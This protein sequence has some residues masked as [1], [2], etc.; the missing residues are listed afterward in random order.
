[1]IFDNKLDRQFAVETPYRFLAIDI[2]HARTLE[3]FVYLLLVIDRYSLLAVGRDTHGR[4]VPGAR[5][6]RRLCFQHARRPS[7]NGLW[8]EQTLTINE[9]AKG[10]WSAGTSFLV[11]LSFKTGLEPAIRS[12]RCRRDCDKNRAF[13]PPRA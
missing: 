10:R 12:A 7:S 4:S 2:T 11:R 1:M 13:W 9:G 3:G 5:A 8:K 6:I